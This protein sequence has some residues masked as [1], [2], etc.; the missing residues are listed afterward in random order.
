MM[1]TMWEQ[2]GIIG[3]GGAAVMLTGY[4][5]QR[6]TKDA[7]TVD[8]LWALSLASAAVFAAITGAGDP[9]RRVLMGAMVG[10]WGLRLGLH[11]LTD[12]VLKS[13][14]D[15]RYAEMRERYGAKAQVFFMAVFATNAVLIVLLSA[16]FVIA[17]ADGRAVGAAALGVWQYVGAALWVVGI[18]GEWI[19]DRQ[20]LEFKRD[21]G[22]KGRVCEIGL[23]R[24]SRH[25]NYFF[26]WVIWCGFAAAAVTGPY[27]WVAVLAPLLMLGLITKVTGIPPTEARSLR[28][29]P[30]AYRRYQK[31]TSA[32]VPWFRKESAT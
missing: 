27:G 8:A 22:N 20:L 19:A 28:S 4:L 31:T 12:R 15:G 21:A 3:A 13:G 11:V 25:P 2:L 18:G 29:R 1:L 10:L 30:E 24:Y 16:V 7:G 9:A 5:V 17:C 32:F 14:E 6:R 23:W 26:E